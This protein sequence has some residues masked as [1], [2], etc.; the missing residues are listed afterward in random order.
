MEAM[1]ESY[2]KE[3][4][5]YHLAKK[6]RPFSDHESLIEL[7]ELNGIKMRSIPHSR[8]STNENLVTFISDGASIMLGKKSGVATRLTLR[9]PE[10][11]VWHCMTHRLELAVSDAVYEV[12]S[13]N[14]FLQKLYSLYRMSNKNKRELKD[15]AAEESSQL[16]HI[17][18]VLD[19]TV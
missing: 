2:M 7:Q 16:L 8:Y 1:T 14:H 13:V 10:L 9:F 18:R 12:N 6:C 3:T 15:A 4:E 17:G 19:A 11:F 5:A